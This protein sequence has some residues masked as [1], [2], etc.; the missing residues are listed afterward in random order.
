[1]HEFFKYNVKKIGVG[2]VKFDID[3]KILKFRF[4]QTFIMHGNLFL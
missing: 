1:M 3:T 4:I 2:D